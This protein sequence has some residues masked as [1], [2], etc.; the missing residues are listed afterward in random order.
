VA[1]D[2]T[3]LARIEKARAW[4]EVARRLAHEIKNP[5]TPIRLSAERLRRRLRKRIPEGEEAEIFDACTQAIVDQVDRLQRLVA[6]FSA[7]A[8]APKPRLR[9]VD[10]RAILGSIADLYRPRPAV[11]VELPKEELWIEVDPDQI[12]QVLINLIENALA[13]L[14]DRAQEGAVRVRIEEQGDAVGWIVED[15]GPGV[16]EKLIERIFEPYVSTREGGTGLGLA[17]ARRIA[18]EHGGEL[19][20]VSRANPTRFVLRLPRHRP[21][22]SQG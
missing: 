16:P 17:I 10:A 14:G 11:R 2:I 5:L 3:E 4:A 6:D 22:I 20:L 7:F 9:R 1:E 8:R 15:D 19:L 13:M 21:S 12:K 18:N